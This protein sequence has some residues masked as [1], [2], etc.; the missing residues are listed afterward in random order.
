MVRKWFSRSIEPSRIAVVLERILLPCARPETVNPLRVL[1]AVEPR[2]L[3]D[4]LHS[5][6]AR[7]PRLTVIEQ[8]SHTV[9][10]L[11]G[12]R[13]YR[14][15][16]VVATFE[17]SSDLPPLVTHL[18]GEFPD[19]LVVGIELQVQRAWTCRNRNEICTDLDFTVSGIIQAILEGSSKRSE[20]DDH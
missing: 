10:I 5:L 20:A 6:L 3:R 19:I 8:E 14:I 4:S 16:V 13:Q 9:D 2:L 7:H 12:V 17:P 1:L 18:L 15:D 11:F